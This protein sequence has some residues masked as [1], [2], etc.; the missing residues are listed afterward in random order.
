[1]LR[2]ILP[3]S[4]IM[5]IERGREFCLCQCASGLSH[6]PSHTNLHPNCHLD[7][8]IKENVN[9]FIQC[10]GSVTFWCGSGSGTPELYL[11]LMDP[12]PDSNPA[13]I[14]SRWNKILHYH[15]RKDDLPSRHLGTGLGLLLWG[16]GAPPV[17]TERT[18]RCAP[19]PKTMDKK[20]SLT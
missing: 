19:H 3:L 20:R 8:I 1:M 18:G 9:S 7:K 10:W 6:I 2:T 12:D 17:W 14:Y 13:P 5:K 4:T 16:R 15:G 11:W